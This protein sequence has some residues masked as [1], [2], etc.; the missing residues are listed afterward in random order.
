MRGRKSS[1]ESG[2]SDEEEGSDHVEGLLNNLSIETEETEEDAAEGL[3][4]AL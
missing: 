1:K 3:E 2:Y 4:A